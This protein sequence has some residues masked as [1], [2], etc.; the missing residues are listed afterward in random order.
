M[1]DAAID[2][3]RIGPNAIIQ[4]IHALAARFGQPA[5]DAF[6]VA[7]GLEH[8]ISE[9]P[10]NMVAER[11]VAI[12]QMELRDRFGSEVAREI[13]IDAGRRTG[14]YLLANRIPRLAQALLRLLPAGL[15]A[16][17]LAKAISKHSWTFAGSGTFSV[18]PDR[19]FR[20]SIQHNPICSRIRSDVPVCD[21]YAATFE[22]IFRAIVHPASRVE[23]TECEAMGAAACVF[24]ISWSGAVL[25]DPR[26]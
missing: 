6:F 17:V 13:C 4:V 9:R 20:F 15:A 2:R 24:E 25:R 23:E 10:G 1:A 16:R 5:A 8:H 18:L 11:D 3:D 7:A 14:D 22:R 21:Y 26:V 12:L 19:P